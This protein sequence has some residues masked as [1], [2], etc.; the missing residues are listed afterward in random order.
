[1]P[2]FLTGTKITFEPDLWRR[3]RSGEDEEWEEEE[4]EEE[5]EE[6]PT[7][8]VEILEVVVPRLPWESIRRMD[9]FGWPNYLYKDKVEAIVAAKKP[10]IL[11][12]YTYIIGRTLWK[13]SGHI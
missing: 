7:S 3:R 13:V 1:M 12:V 9:R 6:I 8:F 5:E 10:Q 11:E 4:E 2:I